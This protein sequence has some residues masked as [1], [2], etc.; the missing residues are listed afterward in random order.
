MKKLLIL[1][2]V[3]AVMAL[4]TSGL[5]PGK[6]E[7]PCHFLK[8][9]PALDGREDKLW[10]SLPWQSGFLV[11]ANGGTHGYA[12]EKPSSFKAGWT[13][14][15]LYILVKC[16]DMQADKL[17]SATLWDNGIEVFICPVRGRDYFQLVTNISGRKWGSV[18]GVQRPD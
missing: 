17:K 11:Y 15:S 3:F 6:Y 14:D 16:Y 2:G 13:K 12:V 4:E 9:T 7:Y 10:N 1:L 5:E 8:E 18:S